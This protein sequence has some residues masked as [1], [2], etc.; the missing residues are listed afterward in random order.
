ASKELE[1]I[2]PKRDIDDQ[3]LLSYALYPKVYKDYLRF[4]EEYNKIQV[5]DTPSFFYG[6]EPNEKIMIEIE[7]GK[8]LLIELTSVGPLREGGLRTVYFDLN[9]LPKKLKCKIEVL[10]VQLWFV[11][12]QIKQIL[13][14][15]GHKCQE[16]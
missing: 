13:N 7:P 3:V 4:Y 6:L 16:Q 10:K 12:K 9:G 11:K 14:K 5:I 2:L 1:Q 15:W 8:S